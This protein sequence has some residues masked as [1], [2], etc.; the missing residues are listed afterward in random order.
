MT[1]KKLKP[2]KVDR[3]AIVVKSSPIHGKGVFV[4]KP[5]KKGQANIRANALAGSWQ[6]NGTPMIQRTQTTL[7]IFL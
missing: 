5:I 3:S 6:R 1:T 2:P 7:F 4:V